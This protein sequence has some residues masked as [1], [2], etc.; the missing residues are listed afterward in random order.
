MNEPLGRD[1]WSLDEYPELLDQEDDTLDALDALS[2]SRLLYPEL[3]LSCIDS[4]LGGPTLRLV[5]SANMSMSS[6]VMS[7]LRLDLP[8]FFF[9]SFRFLSLSFFFFLLPFRL[10]NFCSPPFPGGAIPS[11]PPTLDG[12]SNE[13][14]SSN[15]PF[16]GTFVVA[17]VM[18]TPDDGGLM[19]TLV[20]IVRLYGS[21]PLHLNELNKYTEVHVQ[22][23]MVK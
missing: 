9:L 11:T 4:V 21:P 8:F 12:A 7:T 1:W 13:F 23:N 16:S 22:A 15:P 10:K 20:I 17:L 3:L 19:D 14:A 6:S 2:D 18:F 5:G